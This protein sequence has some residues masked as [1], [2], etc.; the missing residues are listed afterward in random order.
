MNR[1]EINKSR[2]WNCLENHARHGGTKQG[3]VNRETLTS[4][5]KAG[6]DVFV[7]WCI[8]AGMSVG[9][10]QIGNIYAT[11]QGIDPDLAPLMI[12][13]HLDTQPTGGKYDG[14]LGVLGGLEVIRALNDADIE[15][16]RPITLVNW[17][18]EEGS[19]YVPSMMGSGVYSGRFEL[20]Q[21]LQQ[22]DA[23][24]VSVAQA[25]DEIGYVGDEEVGARRFHASLELHIEQG[26]VLENKQIEVGVVTGS[27]AMNWSHVCIEGRPAHAG[28]TPMSHR[29][30]PMQATVRLL[31][32]SYRT[33]HQL[34]DACVT[35][36]SIKTTPA[37][38]S[39]IP[40]R[41]E[42]TLDLRH[43]SN[44]TLAQMVAEFDQAAAVEEAAGFKVS[45][46][47]FGTAKG[48]GFDTDCVDAVR[49][50]AIEGGYSHCD[51]ISGAG[52]DA[53][54]IGEI[55]PTAMIFVPC[56]NGVSHNPAES[57]TPEQ[58][59][60]GVDVLLKAV[61]KLAQ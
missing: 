51:I 38:H 42:L 12:G 14:I 26:P 27:Q 28:T 30:D 23:E 60:A 13:S 10:D 52:H 1:A 5:D 22:T 49:Q 36:G 24:G 57:I 56:L 32:Q 45:R 29:L 40:K 44:E 46:T 53:I 48:R 58:A 61:L 21:M 16:L 47:E 39:T 50:A 37:S 19:R 3:G 59:Y 9:V 55:C 2:L 18:N 4:T 34:K 6:R 41:V 17:T 11:R 15:T 43:P 8:E 20:Q 35:I 33:G 31:E 54:Y 25:L 7:R